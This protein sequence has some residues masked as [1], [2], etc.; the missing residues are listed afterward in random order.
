MIAM[1]S[2]GRKRAFTLIELLVVVSIIALLIAI[3]LPSLK[4]ART[5]AKD[6]VCRSNMHQLG[7][8]LT[9]ERGA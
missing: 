2:R 9:T 5:Q 8:M 4:R 3:L 6:V 1:V 7:A